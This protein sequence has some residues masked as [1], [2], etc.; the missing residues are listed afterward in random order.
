MENTLKKAVERL[1]LTYRL[2]H[3][4]SVRNGSDP[5]QYATE[6]VANFLNYYEESNKT[7]AWNDPVGVIM[8]QIRIVNGMI[9]CY[10]KPVVRDKVTHKTRWSV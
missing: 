10:D 1:W 3:M 6:C 9:E 5:K 2:Y 7:F 8:N 4:V